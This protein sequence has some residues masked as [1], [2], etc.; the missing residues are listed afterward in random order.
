MKLPLLSSKKIRNIQSSGFAPTQIADLNLDLD[1][2][3]NPTIIESGESVGAVSEWLYKNGGGSVIQLTGSRQPLTGVNSIN[4]RNAIAFDGGDDFMERLSFTAS[5]NMTIFAV[6]TVISGA[7]QHKS[8]LSMN[9]PGNGFQI[10][11]GNENEFRARFASQGLGPTEPPIHSS[12]L[13]SIPSIISYRLSDNDGN[14]VLRVN[15][16]QSDEDT[17]NGGLN[18]APT[19]YLGRNRQGNQRLRVDLFRVI[20]YNRDLTLPEMVEVETFLSARSGIVLPDQPADLELWLDASDTS[21]IVD[22]GDSVSRWSDKRGNGNSALQFMGSEQ[23]T[24]R[25]RTING[26]NVLDFDGGDDLMLLDSQPIIGTEARTI[27]VMALGDNGVNQNYIVSLSNNFAGVGGLYRLTT[28]IGIR[29]DGGNRQ[30]PAD[31]VEDGI[32]AAII[33]A[34]NEANSNIENDVNNLQVYKNGVLLSGGASTAPTTPVNTNVGAAAIGDDAQ[35]SGNRLNGI[36]GEVLIYNRVLTAAER[37]ATHTYL[38]NKW[39]INLL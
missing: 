25:T 39:G 37:L 31:A 12:G 23:P 4:G 1:A 8:V 17:Y 26:K 5:A 19:F 30:F 27:I 21:T 16:V 15:G 13:T 14:V 11:K 35:G 32:N 38:S 2:L 28:E 20:I 36:I 6:F 33:T 24:T 22:S 10:D 3:D 18:L 29:I 9:A 7:I 34:T